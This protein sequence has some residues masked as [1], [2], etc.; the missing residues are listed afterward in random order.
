MSW[1]QAHWSL[2][3]TVLSHTC[4]ESNITNNLGCSGRLETLWCLESLYS[5]GRIVC[6]PL[7]SCEVWHLRHSESPRFSS[8]FLC[9]SVIES[10]D[11]DPIAIKHK[12]SNK[13]QFKKHIYTL[14]Y[15]LINIQHILSPLF[16]FGYGIIFSSY[17]FFNYTNCSIQIYPIK[18]W[19]A[20]YLNLT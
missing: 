8:R 11:D 4:Y 17:P 16:Y 18:Y 1:V 20:F 6:V 9:I 13:I 19:N 12:V 15:I 2:A 10:A 7:I 14:K 5:A 3:G